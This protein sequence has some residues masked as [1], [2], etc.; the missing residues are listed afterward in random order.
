MKKIIAKSILVLLGLGFM[1]LMYLASPLFL[2][3]SILLLVFLF[4]LLW[5]VKTLVD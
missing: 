4:T 1:T 2:Y 5:C 3:S